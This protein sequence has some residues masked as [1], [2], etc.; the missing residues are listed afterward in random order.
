MWGRDPS[1]VPSKAL[2]K[3]RQNAKRNRASFACARCKTLKA[4]CSDYRPC[5]KC[6]DT[7]NSD[8]CSKSKGFAATYGDLDLSPVPFQ[9]GS[10]KSSS[11]MLGTTSDEEQRAS[12]R[13]A[14]IQTPVTPRPSVLGEHKEISQRLP[15][16]I[17]YDTSAWASGAD[18][19]GEMMAPPGNLNGR[20]PV[21]F[22]RFSHPQHILRSFQEL[23]PEMLQRQN[24]VLAAPSLPQATPRFQPLTSSYCASSQSMDLSARSFYSQAISDQ[25]Q[26]TPPAPPCFPPH[27]A[28]GPED[29]HFMDPILSSRMNPTYIVH[30]IFMTASPKH[31]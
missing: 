29:R 31:N 20:L 9:K 6:M 12:L 27:I 28:G 3:A 30:Y 1:E 7:K 18:E 19:H 15:A 10:I 26:R 23:V 25:A 2:Q 22:L 17:T 11:W 5:K 4:K 13:P 16:D 21:D 8:S 14:H 24:E